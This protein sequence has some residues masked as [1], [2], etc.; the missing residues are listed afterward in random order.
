MLVNVLMVIK[1]RLYIFKSVTMK[2]II[3]QKELFYQ[4][5]LVNGVIFNVRNKA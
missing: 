1:L 3:T 5:L 4:D 2:S